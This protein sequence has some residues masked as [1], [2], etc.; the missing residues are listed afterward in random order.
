MKFKEIHI[1]VICTR[2]SLPRQTLNVGLKP[3]LY[4]VSD[5]PISSFCEPEWKNAL[6]FLG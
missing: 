6:F 5:I 1:S 2:Q 4:C 3:C